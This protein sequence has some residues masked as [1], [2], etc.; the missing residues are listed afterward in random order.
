MK[1][2][3]VEIKNFL[4]IEE[5]KVDFDSYGNIVRI[6]GKNRDTK[7]ISS[8]GAGKSSVIESIVFALFGRT[9]RKTTDKSLQNHYTKGKCEVRI[10]VNDNIVIRRVKRPPM[11]VVT[12]GGENVTQDSIQATQKYLDKILNTNFSV[13]LASMVFGQSNKMN[14]LTATADEKRNI[15]QSFLDIG[16]VFQYRKAIKSKKA[17]AYSAKKISETLCSEV[18]SKKEKLESKISKIKTY[19]KDAKV[20][21]TSDKAKLF[22]KHSISELQENEQRRYAT[23]V[24]LESSSHGLSNVRSRISDL[25]AKLKSFKLSSCEFCGETPAKERALVLEWE[26]ELDSKKDEE[27]SCKTNIKSLN[28]KLDEFGPEVTAMDFDL[29]ETFK[30]FDTEHKILA[31]QRRDHT[32]LLAKHQKEVERAQRDYD[33]MRFWEQAFSEQGLMRFVIRNILTFFNDRVNYYLKFLSS[34]NFSV[35][36]D[37]TLKEEIYNKGTLTFF[38]ALSGGEK[39]KVSLAIMLG[40]NDLLLLSGKERSN[41]IFFDE[42]ADSLDDGGVKGLYELILDISNNKKVFVITHND[43]LNSLLE[44]ESENLHVSKKSNITTIQ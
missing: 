30:S 1:I 38:E 10:T 28:S 12:V 33:I 44:D 22:T 15:I 17:K 26:S 18:L 9:I 32:K 8:N 4:S 41:L 21:M 31:A 25:R 42:V 27:V 40:L 6:V 29:F 20:L 37:E 16:D 7:P 2:N 13:F 11:L 35:T 24:D 14:F 23:K 39:R 36:F 3:R 34:S 43:Y 5:E 19:K